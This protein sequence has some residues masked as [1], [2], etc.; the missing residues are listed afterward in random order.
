MHPG[1]VYRIIKKLISRR[2]QINLVFVFRQTG[3]YLDK[4]TFTSAE[5][6]AVNNKEDFYTQVTPLMFKKY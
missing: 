6:Q 3:D 4:T 1:I 5:L 2:G